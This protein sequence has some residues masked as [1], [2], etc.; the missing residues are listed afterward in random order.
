MRC[1]R[2]DRP[3]VPQAVGRTPEGLV[4]FGWCLDCLTK[5]GCTDVVVARPETRHAR[6]RQVGRA[7][8]EPFSR[9]RSACLR[10]RALALVIALLGGWG[11]LLMASGGW[12]LWRHVPRAASPLGNGTPIFLL[13]GG[14]A[15]AAIGLL[16]GALVFGRT[17]LRSRPVL[18]AVQGVAFA[19]A[20]AILLAGVFHHVPRRDP[21][22]VVFAAAALAVSAGARTLERLR[23]VPS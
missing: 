20:L 17:L 2:C 1:T 7:P 22:I 16:L 14:A 5:V 23:R 18:R 13:V 4:V 21:L 19:V 11:A 10:R 6:S 3:A 8:L 9:S 12:M 15:T